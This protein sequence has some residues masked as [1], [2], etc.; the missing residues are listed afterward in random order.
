MI[1]KYRPR[2]P[3]VG[4]TLIELLVAILIIAI[5]ATIGIPNFQQTIRNNRV[6]SQSNELVALIS[7]SKS[8]AIR[9]SED[10]TVQFSDEGNVWTALV[11]DPAGTATVDGCGPGVLRCAEHRAVR[12]LNAPAELTFNNRGY[13]TNTVGGWATRTVYLEHDG[14]TG[15]RQRRRIDILPTGQINSCTLACGDEDTACP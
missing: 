14:C 5:L 7:Y 13:T 9:R 8:E 2:S 12:L 3:A 4:V 1:Y 15:L 10:V 11:E 6:T